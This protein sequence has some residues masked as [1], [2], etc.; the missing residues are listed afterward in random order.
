MEATLVECC[1]NWKEV[2]A[3]ASG[4]ELLGSM[5]HMTLVHHG[6]WY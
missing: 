4:K 6:R 5:A 3:T 2:K 1:E